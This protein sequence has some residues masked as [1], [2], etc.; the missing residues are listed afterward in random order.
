MTAS[1]V[2]LKRAF[3][4][5]DFD[6]FA[7]VSGDN[8]PIHVDPEFSSRTRFGRTVAHGLLINTVLRGLLEQLSPGGRQQAQELMFPAP[9]Y[10][11]EDMEF[12]VERTDERGFSFTVTR[13]SDGTV[14]CTGSTTMAGDT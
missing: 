2:V 9:T 13:M 6:R 14:T 7:E 11:D 1:R 8:N 5:E 12:V 3:T 4:Q 10:A